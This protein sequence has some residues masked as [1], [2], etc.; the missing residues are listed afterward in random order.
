MT[1][2]IRLEDFHFRAY[3]K[4]R[5]GDTDRQGHVNNVVFGVFFETGRVEIIN[6]RSWR[7]D[8]ASFVIAHVQIDYVAEIFWPGRV[9]VG[10]NIVKVGRSSV[11]FSQAA[12]QNTRLVAKAQA[13]LVY[14]D[15]ATHR[16][17]P[18]PDEARADF[19]RS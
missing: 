8:Q 17:T 1:D 4:L 5:Y 10:T 15:N 16:S 13:V 12:F 11:S 18:L 7:H 14:V 6:G 3:D 9:D 19:T 2:P